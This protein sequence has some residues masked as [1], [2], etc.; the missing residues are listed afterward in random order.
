MHISGPGASNTTKIPLIFFFVWPKSAPA[1]DLLDWTTH[2]VITSSKRKSLSQIGC[3]TTQRA[4][5]ATLLGKPL[6]ASCCVHGPQTVVISNKCGF[7]PYDFMAFFG[8]PFEQVQFLPLVTFCPFWPF[9]LKPFLSNGTLL[10]RV[11]EGSWSFCGL[12]TRLRV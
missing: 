4:Y 10:T 1:K 6:G 7:T 3:D 5:A 8:P 2:C 11:V 9:W 12:S